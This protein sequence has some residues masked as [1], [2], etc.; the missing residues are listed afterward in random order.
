MRVD[1]HSQAEPTGPFSWSKSPQVKVEKWITGHRFDLF[2]GS[3]NGYSRL[4]SP[5]IHR[6]WVFHRKPD[7]WMVCDLAE[8]HGS[9]QLDV[10]WHLG[11]GLSPEPEKKGLFTGAQETLRLL[12]VEGGDWTESQLLD[13]WSPA[14]GHKEPATVINFGGLV[15][16]PADFA[17][18]LLASQE[19]TVTDC[20]RLVRIGESSNG[21]VCGYRYSNSTQEH[22]FFFARQRG[23]WAMGAWAS[24]ADFLYT[25]FDRE[26]EECRLVLCDGTY[27]EAG[28]RRTINCDRQVGYAEV[29]SNGMKADLFTS[30]PGHVALKHPLD[31]VWADENL[32]AP[33]NLPKGTGV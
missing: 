24:D 20:G 23:A 12:T 14:Y 17:T 16:L 8:G 32:S 27:A 2:K 13:Y 15:N 33:G 18:L 19:T 25:S 21:L 1:G 22:C 3:H 26:S 30:D 11:P 9:H 31:R 29:L 4:P 6:R 7:F 10:G 28:R 5:V